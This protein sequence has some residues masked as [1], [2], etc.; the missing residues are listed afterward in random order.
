MASVSAP[1]Q[2]QAP[3]PPEQRFLIRAIEWQ[4]YRTISEALKGRHLRLTYDQGNLELMTISGTHGNCSRLLGRFVFVLAEEYNRTVRSFGDMTCAS[5]ELDRGVEPDESFYLTNEP[6]V[7]DKEEIDLA[8][9]P[10]PDLMLEIDIRR[11]SRTRMAIYA[12]MRVPEVWQFNG[13]TL[14]VWRLDADGNY[15]S[16]DTSQ[17]FPS[18]PISELAVFLQRRTQ[19]DEVSLVR[20]FRA[21]VGDQ[22]AKKNQP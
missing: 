8:T 12:A 3:L 10:P 2:E 17:Y 18:L 20:S 1:F 15:V 22:L 11:S 4:T 9:D 19:M 5:E 6:V 13:E 21:W 16:S 14:H 7:R